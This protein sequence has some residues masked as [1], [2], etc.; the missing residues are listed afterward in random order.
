MALKIHQRCFFIFLFDKKVLLQKKDNRFDK[1]IKI[2]T[3][4]T[5]N[6]Q[7]QIVKCFYRETCRVHIGFV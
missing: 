5:K 1:N 7:K 4:K 2:F 6:Q 3:C